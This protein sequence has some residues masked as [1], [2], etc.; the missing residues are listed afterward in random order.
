MHG[1]GDGDHAVD[2][3]QWTG[4][5]NAKESKSELMCSSRKDKRHLLI[6]SENA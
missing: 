3:I 4:S 5:A 6:D 2:W 1:I